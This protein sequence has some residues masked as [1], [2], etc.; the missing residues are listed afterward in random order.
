MKDPFKAFTD[1]FL[2]QEQIDL[3][4]NQAKDSK[5]VSLDD[6]TNFFDLLPLTSEI[7]ELEGFHP[8]FAE[9]ALAMTLVMPLSY[10]ALTMPGF[11][12]HRKMLDKVD[13]KYQPENPHRPM[14]EADFIMWSLFDVE[15]EN[16]TKVLADVVRPLQASL[17]IDED[18]MD[19]I[20]RMRMSYTGVYLCEEKS[21]ESFILKEIPSGRQIEAILEPGWDEEIAEGDILLIRLI[22]DILEGTYIQLSSP[23]LVNSTENDWIEFFSEHGIEQGETF[24]FEAYRVF[25]KRGIAPDF[26]LNYIDSACLSI[27]NMVVILEGTPLLSV[28]K[29]VR[30]F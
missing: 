15:V 27:S 10:I 18:Q 19:L 8:L 12:N 16:T 11:K 1:E 23:Y 4:K 9:C 21:E 13:A 17:K 22:E 30:R 24:D 7:G 6:E 29:D 2:K 28:K 26:W 14:F 20:E 5:I 3:S 25:M